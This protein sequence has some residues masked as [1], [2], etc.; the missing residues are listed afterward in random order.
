METAFDGSIRNLLLMSHTTKAS[1]LAA[2]VSRSVA[3]LGVDTTILVV[4][5]EQ[6]ALRQLPEPGKATGP[7]Q[8][9]DG[10]PAGRAFTSITMQSSGPDTNRLWV[11]ILDGT[12]RL[13]V[14]EVSLPAH[15][16]GDDEAI[17]VGCEAI[18]GL[19]GHLLQAKSGLGDSIEVARRS[20][21]MSV[22]SELLLRLV[23]PTTFACDELMLSAVLEPSYDVGGDAFDYSVDDDMARIGIFDAIGHGLPACLTSAVAVSAIRAARRAGQGLYESTR[24]AD[25]EIQAQWHDARFVT[26]V[27]A[28][29]RLDTGVLRYINAGH[30]PPLVLRGSRIVHRLDQ[31]RRLPL[32]L[33]DASTEIATVRLEPGDRVLFYTDGVIEARDKD[34][35]MFGLARLVELTE[36]HAAGQLATAEIL[37]RI[38]HAVLSHQVGQLQDDATLLLAEWSHTAARRAR[39]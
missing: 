18:A 17:R 3:H 9:I 24:A 8:P 16:S 35:E 23:P 21:P 2:A 14:L 26:A 38:C 11:P 7:V 27:L 15:L 30:P 10:S 31:G 39:P 25:V 36:H 1:A 22:A 29:L 33:D 32:G 5:Y 19:I 28:D 13:G 20:Q 12:E 37:R 34:D 4:D 6:M